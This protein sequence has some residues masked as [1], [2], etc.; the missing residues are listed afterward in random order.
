VSG[1]KPLVGPDGVAVTLT[2]GPDGKATLKPI[3]I[4]KPEAVTEREKQEKLAKQRMHRQVALEM[5][6]SDQLL[7]SM[8][9]LQTEHEANLARVDEAI[10]VAAYL[11][12]QTGGHQ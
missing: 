10:K 1:D 6:N 2:V 5:F 12:E 11:I 8:S 4:I 7:V 9:H 3:E